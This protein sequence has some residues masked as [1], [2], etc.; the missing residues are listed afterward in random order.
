MFVGHW[1]EYSLAELKFFYQ[2][3]GLEIIETENIQSIRPRVFGI[4]GR[5][6]YVNFF[7]LLSYVLPGMRDTNIIFGK[8]INVCD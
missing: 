6:I 8:K 4:W 5:G 2:W 1:R 7:R 3:S